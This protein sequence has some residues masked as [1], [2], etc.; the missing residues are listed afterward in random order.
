MII[1]TESFIDAAN[2]I[3]VLRVQTDYS[4]LTWPQYDFITETKY[5][6]QNQQLCLHVFFPAFPRQ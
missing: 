2:H 1:S 5:V 4:N 6:R 3:N